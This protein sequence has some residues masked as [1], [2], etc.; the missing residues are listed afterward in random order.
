VG[1]G[2]LH[3]REGTANPENDEKVKDKGMQTTPSDDVLI[4]REGRAGRITMNRPKALNALTHG[5]VGPIWDAMVAWK[6]DPAVELVLLDGAGERALCAGGD[7]RTLYESRGHGSAHARAFWRDEYRLNALIGRYRKPFVAIQD[8]I[9]MGG[10][11]GLSGHACHRIVTERSQLAMPETGIG[12][13]PDVG[14]TWLLAHAPGETGIYLGLT[15]EPMGAADAIYAGFSEAF[16]PA[17]MLSELKGRLVDRRGAPPRE[18]IGELARPARQAGLEERRAD[19]DRAFGRAT[20][21]AIIQELA[22]MPG[23]WAEKTRAALAQK[24][25]K[26]LKLTFAAIRNARRL[27]SLEEALEVEFRLCTR[28]F[29]DGE[30]PEGVR[31]LIIDKDRSPKWSPADLAGVTPALVESYLAPLPPDEE[32][33]LSANR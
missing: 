15:G 26:S 30:F 27:S 32:L 12:L 10:G 18:V 14:G 3:R 9:V 19:I 22:A 29:E 8:G 23:E 21:E 1:L 2:Q 11:I 24:S 16:V 7:V 25:P 28:L 31:A 13:I 6:D 17:A 20:V 4:R 5:M 33:G